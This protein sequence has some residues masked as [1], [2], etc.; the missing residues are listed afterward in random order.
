MTV[1]PLLKSG[2]E[3]TMDYS[4]I[5]S[6]C[7]AIAVTFGV[8][9]I[10]SPPA[11]GKTGP[12]VVVAPHDIVSRRISYADLNLASS[13]GEMTLNGR[14]RGAIGSLCSE[15]VEGNDA[16]FTTRLRDRNCRGSAWS[17]ATPQIERAVA[18]AHEIASTGTSTI[19]AAGIVIMLPK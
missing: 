14:V 12:V 16:S 19:A 3:H 8:F 7:G 18:R 1:Q 2:K 5:L 11:Y 17:M 9:A 13:A 15:A 10:V 4:K 6:A